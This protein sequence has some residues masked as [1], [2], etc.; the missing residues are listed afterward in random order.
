MREPR[1]YPLIDM[2]TDG[3]EKV[4]MFFSMNEADIRRHHE[5]YLEEII[6]GSLRLISRDG[7]A[8]PENASV[9]CPRCGAKMKTI[10][11]ATNRERQN[12]YTCRSCKN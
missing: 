12:L 8:L 11:S 9:R 6:P 2:D 7:K 1:Y 4:P 5:F 3:T 10:G